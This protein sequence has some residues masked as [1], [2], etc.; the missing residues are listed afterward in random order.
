[1]LRRPISY[2]APCLSGALLFAACSE[3]GPNDELVDENGENDE[4]ATVEPGTS[5]VDE[6]KSSDNPGG[7]TNEE[8]TGGDSGGTAQDQL[9]PVFVAQGSVGRSTI[10]CDDGKTWIKNRSYDLEGAA[11]ACEDTTPVV[12]GDTSC[13]FFNVGNDTCE[14]KEPC[15][16]DHHPGADKG[17]V[18]GKDVFAAVWGWGPKGALKTS[19][20]GTIW[21]VPS[22]NVDQ[23]TYAGVAFGNGTF[24]A[25]SRKP[26]VSTDGK[27]WTEGGTAD[28]Q[29]AAE[30][31]IHN[32]RDIGFAAT[33]SGVFVMG[34]SSA[35]GSDL[36]VSKDEGA[37]WQRPTGSWTC[38]GDFTG[39]AGDETIIVATFDD[40]VC[41]STDDGSSFAVLDG[42]FTSA[43]ALVHDG[44]QFVAWDNSSRYTS[45]NGT[46]WTETALVTKD[47]R[48]GHG[49]HL[50]PVARSDQGTYVSVRGGWSN[51]YG[52]QDF[53][54]SEDGIVWTALPEGSFEPSHRIRAMTFGYAPAAACE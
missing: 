23:S 19:Q 35:P 16:C 30:E 13:T 2:F 41:V 29:N 32:T 53:Y 47:L 31:T 36:L 18:F 20:D 34:A 25:A 4:Q 8:G 6:E 54:R 50:G 51:W 27:T 7:D 12:C 5:D 42:N 10:S 38:G 43:V 45:K 39:V 37:S 40:K 24:V 21:S 33:E 22:S 48:D 9:V 11:E 17:V 15:D 28:F 44:A 3:S 49:F 26:M 14:T 1:M 46:E 52:K